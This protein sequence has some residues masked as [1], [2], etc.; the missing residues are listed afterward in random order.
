[1]IIL[2]NITYD[3]YVCVMQL[4]KI[5]LNCNS[6]ATGNELTSDHLGMIS[7]YAIGSQLQTARSY[8]P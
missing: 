8:Q 5:W 6:L 7:K 4:H 3:I 1:M 2:H